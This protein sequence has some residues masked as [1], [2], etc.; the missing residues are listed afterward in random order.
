MIA[1]ASK[2][3]PIDSQAGSTSALLFIAPSLNSGGRSSETQRDKQRQYQ[4]ACCR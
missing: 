4:A 2:I 3:Q 1:A